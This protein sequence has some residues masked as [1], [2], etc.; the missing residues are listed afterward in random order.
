MIP[1]TKNKI[2]LRNIE[3]EIDFYFDL[4]DIHTDN[5]GNL[6]KVSLNYKPIIEDF[7]DGNYENNWVNIITNERKKIYI[8]NDDGIDDSNDTIKLVKPEE[9]ENY[10]FSRDNICKSS[11]GL[12]NKLNNNDIFEKLPDI[13]KNFNPYEN[14]DFNNHTS[15]LTDNINQNSFSYRNCINNECICFYNDKLSFCNEKFIL[16]SIDGPIYTYD[17]EEKKIGDKTK[18][19]L[20]TTNQNILIP[21]EKVNVVG[22]L[23]NPSL[24]ESLNH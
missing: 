14:M 7:L 21:G 11:S 10:I 17:D 1:K 4:K 16:R 22:L 13:L 6:K 20:I 24:F 3:K 5:F 2:I 18:I 19:Q 9:L 12:G 8:E 23:L 15:Y